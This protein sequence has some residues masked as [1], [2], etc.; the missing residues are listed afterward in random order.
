M[1]QITEREVDLIISNQDK[2]YELTQKSF[3]KLD[4]LAEKVECIGNRTSKL[5]VKAGFWGAI[6][7]IF[8]QILGLFWK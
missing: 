6:G 7:G 1:T 8:T 2:I 5:E 4:K 3:D